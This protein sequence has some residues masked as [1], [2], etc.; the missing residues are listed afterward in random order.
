MSKFERWVRAWVMAVLVFVTIAAVTFAIAH[1]VFT[2]PI[3]VVIVPVLLIIGG[4]ATVI[5]EEG[6][7]RWTEDE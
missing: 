5:Y 2:Y 4:I 6:D 7:R 3:V 1:F